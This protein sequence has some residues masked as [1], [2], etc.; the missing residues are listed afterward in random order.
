MSSSIGDANQALLEIRRQR[1]LRGPLGDGTLRLGPGEL[2]VLEGESGSGKSRLLRNIVD[3]EPELEGEIL[4]G[5]RSSREIPPTVLRKEISLLPQELPI[6]PC[7]GRE[8]L[9]LIRGFEINRDSHRSVAETVG[10]LELFELE[11]HLDKKLDLLSGG[12]KRRLA[13]VAGLIPRPRVLLLD[14]PEAGLDARRRESLEL[15]TRKLLDEGLAILWVSH[16]GQDTFF[17]GAPRYLIE[18]S[19]L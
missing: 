10:W 19:A 18:R 12:E 2:G 3:L 9:E 16:L 6:H 7:T 17:A 1:G 11:P 8:L 4:L 5:G 15:Y 13:L 14:E